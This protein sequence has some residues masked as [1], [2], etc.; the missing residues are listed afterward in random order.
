LRTNASGVL[1]FGT[2]AVTAGG[3]G[4]TTSTGSGNVVLSTSPTLVTPTLGVA[5][6]T[7]LQGI[8]GNVTPAAGTFTTVTGSNDASINGLTVG[9]GSG[10]ISTNTVLGASALGTTNTE[11]AQTAVGYQALTSVTSGGFINSAFGW[12]ALKANTTG[13]TNVG[14]GARALTG[15]LS[16]SNSTAV[17]YQALQA[18]T[19]GAGN[20]A[21]GYQAG[22]SNLT[23]IYNVYYGFLSGYLS[24]GGRNTFIGTTA[25]YNC[26]GSSNTFVGSLDSTGAYAAGNAVTSGSNNTILGAYS[27]NQDGL[28]IRTVSNYVV[29]A[30]G[31]GNRQITMKEGQTLAL[32]S[33]VP[34]AGTGITFP[35]TQSASTDANTL[36]DYEEGTFT[37]GSITG[38][39]LTSLSLNYGSYTKVGRLVTLN[40]SINATVTSS[41]TLTYVALSPP[42]NPSVSTTGSGF[43]SNNV[44]VG[45]SEISGTTVY[46]F[47]PAASEPVAGA[48]I[49]K[50]SIT[51]TF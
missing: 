39:N 27:G 12:E 16:G 25:G 17:G 1:S 22:Y 49:I 51:Y 20:T 11:G 44:R 34:N 29:L 40:F 48:E 45:V 36:D 37:G 3:T 18:N 4:V 42:F 31:D 5:T 38:V 46:V 33:A 15:N 13:T 26:A 35:A 43:L 23:S 28:D 14:I 50:A 21:V 6:A 24:T 8:I 2:L 7:S 19:S 41:N 47:F 9:R 32:D 30:D 10:S